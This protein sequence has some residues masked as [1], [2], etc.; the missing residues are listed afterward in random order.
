MRRY[1]QRL[2]VPSHGWDEK[3]TLCR[4]VLLPPKR[5][6]VP[7][8]PSLWVCGEA[9]DSHALL[10]T[11]QAGPVPR[12][13]PKAAPGEPTTTGRTASLPHGRQ[14]IVSLS[15]CLVPP[16]DRFPVLVSRGGRGAEPGGRGGAAAARRAR[17]AGV[18]GAGL[19]R[20]VLVSSSPCSLQTRRLSAPVM[21]ERSSA[22]VTY[23]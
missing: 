19:V 20:W 15:V 8:L 14:R 21:V 9:H 11:P 7:S 3:V 22:A 12:R 10:G 5:W 13:A 23:W 1:L 4:P 18:C 17:R 6:N 2:D 16:V